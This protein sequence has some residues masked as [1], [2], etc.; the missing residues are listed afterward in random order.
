MGWGIALARALVFLLLSGVNAELLMP[1]MPGDEGS[2][3]S[4]DIAPT[5]D[6][7]LW[8]SLPLLMPG[9]LG[10]VLGLPV[11]NAAISFFFF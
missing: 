6:V 8:A 10:G 3:E 4:S 11:L 5:D 2:A 1:K 9:E 7:I